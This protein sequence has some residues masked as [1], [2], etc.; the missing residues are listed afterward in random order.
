[1]VD[2][3]HTSVSDDPAVLQVSELSFFIQDVEL[4]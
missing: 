4:F 3:G 2:E 1:M